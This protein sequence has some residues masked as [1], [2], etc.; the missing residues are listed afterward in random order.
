MS[1][2]VVCDIDGVIADCSHRL[3]WAEAKMYDDFYARVSGDEPISDGITLLLKLAAHLDSGDRIVFLTGRREDCRQDTMDW[4][5][6]NF[7]YSYE[8]IYMRRKGDHRE[9]YIVKKELYAEIIRMFESRNIIFDH[10]YFIDDDPENVKAV[11]EGDDFV[12][13]LTF[14]INRLKEE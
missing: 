5:R 8:A 7:C 2:L 3:S 9:P 4:L 12:T 13:G 14:G 10:I 11:C 1:N 6:K